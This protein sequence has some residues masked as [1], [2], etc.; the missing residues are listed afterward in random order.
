MASKKRRLRDRDNQ[1]FQ[2]GDLAK[3]LR[4][5]YEAS[6][7]ILPFWCAVVFCHLFLCMKF[8]GHWVYIHAVLLNAAQ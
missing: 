2:L 5:K 3:L 6:V 1:S 4:R 8:L 7:E